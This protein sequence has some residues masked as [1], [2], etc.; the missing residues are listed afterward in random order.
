MN[1]NAPLGS[2]A[3]H[4]H[5]PSGAMKWESQNAAATEKTGDWL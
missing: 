3:S 2:F 1:R 5:E 4:A